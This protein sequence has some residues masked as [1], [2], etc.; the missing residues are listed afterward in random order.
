MSKSKC[1]VD[2]GEC[3]LKETCGGCV[4]TDGRPFGGECVVAV[5]CHSKGQER[6]DKC[7]DSLCNLKNQLILEFNALGIKDMEE[8]TSL[9]SLK[10][11]FINVEYKLQSGQ[12]IKIWDDNKIYLGNQVCKKNSDRCYGLGA[13]ENHL[14][15]CEYGDG[16]SDAE[17]IIYKKR[18]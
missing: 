6:C 17:I 9:N 1:G 11:S 14:L 13:D 18:D 3:R 15:V 16:G 7:S 10:G 12:E 5:C 8:V 2:C 4:E